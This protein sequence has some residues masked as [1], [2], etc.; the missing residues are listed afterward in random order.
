MRMRRPRG[1]PVILLATAVA[2]LANCGEHAGPT[3]P[4]ETSAP[5]AQPAARAAV[6]GAVVTVTFGRAAG[7]TT[8]ADAD[9]R[10]VLRTIPVGPLS[11]TVS[12]PGFGTVTRTADIGANTVMDISVSGTS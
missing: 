11:F 4:W 10:Y 12:A 1:T 7:R 5:V 3:A 2:I 6:A 8:S 9:G